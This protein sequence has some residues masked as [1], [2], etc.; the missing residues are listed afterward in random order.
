VQN[1]IEQRAVYL[2]T[3][4]VMNKAQFSEPVHEEANPR[5]GRANHLGQSFLTDLGHNG[6][7][8]SLLAEMSQQQ[9]NPGESF[10]TGIEQLVDEVIF[11]ADIA[12]QQVRDKHVG[13]RVFAVKHTHHHLLVHPQQLAVGHGRGGPHAQEL[14]GQRSLTKKVSL[15]DYADRRFLARLGHYR[16]PHFAFL[17]IEDSI[18]RVPLC[19]NPLLF[20]NRHKL[21]AIADRREEN[22]LPSPIV[23]RKMLGSNSRSFL[24]T[25]IR[26]MFVIS[27]SSKS[28][29]D[30]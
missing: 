3:A 14:P 19:V 2:Q 23:A 29:G 13:K 25:A 4:V 22:F 6:I 24:T 27:R 21:P 10:F 1:D 28:Q 17:N 20:Q 11:V 30:C 15:A 8:N 26:A 16:E 5:A 9:Q 7:G 18:R 12:R